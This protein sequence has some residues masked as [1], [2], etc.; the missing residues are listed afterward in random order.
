M[1]GRDDGGSG[2]AGCRG[3]HAADHLSPPTL[4]ACDRL[5]HT[6][7]HTRQPPPDARHTPRHTPPHR[8]GHILRQTHATSLI[9]PL[10]YLA[11]LVLVL[12]LALIRMVQRRAFLTD[13]LF[14]C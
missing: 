2:D 14:S 6:P 7:P 8:M 10:A 9:T 4:A 11:T 1:G 3:R 12:L 5:G 13:S